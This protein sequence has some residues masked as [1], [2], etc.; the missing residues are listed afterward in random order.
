MDGAYQAQDNREYAESKD[1][2]LYF[3]GI[4]GPKGNFEFI[5]SENGLSVFDK[6]T[7][8]LYHIL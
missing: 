1:I 5:K 7:G 4:Q 8:N 3:T 6:Q 2:K